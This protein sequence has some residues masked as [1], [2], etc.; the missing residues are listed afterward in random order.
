MEST[1]S[2]DIPA[3]FSAC[4][5]MPYLLV[6][7]KQFSQLGQSAH[8]RQQQDILIQILLEDGPLARRDLIGLVD[9]LTIFNFDEVLRDIHRFLQV[10]NDNYTFCHNR[11]QLWFKSKL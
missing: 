7:D 11:F 5:R 9:N 6:L 3:F 10:R 4:S 2:Q 8:L 1:K